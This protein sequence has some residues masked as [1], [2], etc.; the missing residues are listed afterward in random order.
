VLALLA[1]WFFILKA[2]KA[3]LFA[4]LCKTKKARDIRGP[5]IRKG[6]IV[7]TVVTNWL[8]AL[9]HP[10]YAQVVLFFLF[11]ALAAEWLYAARPAE[12]E[13][14]KMERVVLRVTE[15]NE[16]F[17][18]APQGA[19]ISL[20]QRHRHQ[21]KSGAPGESCPTRAMFSIARTGGGEVLLTSSVSAALK[22]KIDTLI[23]GGGGGANVFGAAV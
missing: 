15:P 13:D 18:S 3:R 7:A 2:V 16:F 23:T 9:G 6:L 10:P 12:V 5:I 17:N 22:R 1:A 19:F 4:R 11:A 14:K 8:L 21:I 20:S